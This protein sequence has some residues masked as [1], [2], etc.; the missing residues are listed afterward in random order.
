MYW[1]GTWPGGPT[2]VFLAGHG[3]VSI[4][5]SN[6]VLGERFRTSGA[7]TRPPRPCLVDPLNPLAT[8]ATPPEISINEPILLRDEP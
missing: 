5:S 1:L 7:F 2:D 3:Y 8:T 4:V 6:T